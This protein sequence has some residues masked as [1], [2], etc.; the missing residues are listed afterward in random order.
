[1][2][3]MLRKAIF[4]PRRV[5]VSTAKTVA[6]SGNLLNLARVMDGIRTFKKKILQNLKSLTFMRAFTGMCFAL[7]SLQLHE[8]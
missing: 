4:V 8:D 2:I 6:P 5:I 7:V 3:V 1:M